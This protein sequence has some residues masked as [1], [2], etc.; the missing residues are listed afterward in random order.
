[1]AKE[2]DIPDLPTEIT[3]QSQDFGG[4]DIDV[5]RRAELADYA[6]VKGCMVIRPYGY[7]IWERMQQALDRR[8]KET[9]HV[10]RLLPAAHPGELPEEGGRARRGLRARRCAVVT[11]GGQRSSRSRSSSGRPPRRSSGTMYTQVDRSPTA[12]CRS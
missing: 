3:P 9:G 7:A 6:P 11:Q 1:M 2:T 12:T 8:F 4:W 10:E 5:V